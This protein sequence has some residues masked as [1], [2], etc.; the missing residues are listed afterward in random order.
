[1]S[2]YFGIFMFLILAKL[3]TFLA[4]A[5][6]SSAKYSS[7]KLKWI[8]AFKRIILKKQHELFEHNNDRA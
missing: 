2:I 1:M 6:K 4:Y 8:D 3:L 7:D 5:F